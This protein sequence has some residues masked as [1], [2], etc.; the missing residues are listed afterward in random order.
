M[1]W[2]SLCEQHRQRNLDQK[3][4]LLTHVQVVSGS[5]IDEAE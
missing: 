1:Q 5:K 3:V 4:W 2:W